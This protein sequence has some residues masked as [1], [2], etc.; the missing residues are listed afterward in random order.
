[1]SQTLFQV[2]VVDS[3]RVVDLTL[4]VMLDSGEF[5]RIN[6]SL[7]ELV[8]K[9]PQVWWVLDLSQLSYMGSSALGLMVNLRA[10][11]KRAGGKLI[12]CGMSPRLYQIFKTTSMHRLF[13]IKANRAEALRA[14]GVK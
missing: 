12:L 14:V 7:L 8:N 4:P 13:D 10:Q 2:S 11:I 6:E 1:M 9:E 5:D 3:A